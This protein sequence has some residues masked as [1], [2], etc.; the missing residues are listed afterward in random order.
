MSKNKKTIVITGAS[1]GIGKAIAIRLAKDGYK[2]FI[3]GRDQNRLDSVAKDCGGDVTSLNFDIN[4]AAARGKAIK[5]I[6]EIDVLIN[7]A[8][9]WQK[10]G[11]L[12][13][14]S[15]DRIAE[16]INTN[17]TS[18]ILLTK[19]LLPFI[20]DANG[21]I[22]NIISKSGVVAQEGQTAYTASKYGMRGF[23]DV[24]R[25]DLKKYNV[26]VGAVYQSGTNTEMFH[27]AGD[28]P[29]V[30]SFTE[31]ADLA[32]LVAY[33]VNNPKKMWINEVRVEK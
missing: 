26:N 19:K 21:S 24:M 27:K 1:D 32:D 23:T 5:S 16:I 4:D 14:I 13:S 20:K 10:L 15:D 22:I 29:P 9:I 7:N 17:L 6:N 2:L 33:M 8:G 30:D 31:P 11:D 3:C 12:D 18:Q 25:Q 28:N